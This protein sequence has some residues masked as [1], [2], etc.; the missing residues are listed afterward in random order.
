MNKEY[1]KKIVDEGRR[2]SELT[3]DNAIAKLTK[4]ITTVFILNGLHRQIAAE[5]FAQEVQASVGSLYNELMTDPSYA[6]IRDTEIAYIFSEGMKGRLGSDKDVVI[7]YKSMLRWIE[8]Y[9]N[10]Q[11]RRD[12]MAIVAKERY[13][14][15]TRQ[16]AVRNVTDDDIMNDIKLALNDYLEYKRQKI[17]RASNNLP[18][19]FGELALP[20]LVKDL[21]GSKM[22]YLI[23]EGYAKDG[24]QFVDVL[25]RAISHGKVF[26]KV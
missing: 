17:E 7:T 15:P 21:G 25:E 10:H 24:E 1:I 20:Y 12:A 22:R 13:V 3:K 23:R 2:F 5:A 11:E 18:K 4:D 8:G 9:L 16:I 19:R 14:E 26:K 6:S